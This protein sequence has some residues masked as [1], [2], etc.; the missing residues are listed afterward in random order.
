M[1]T[2]KGQKHKV[3]DL[4]G[5][6]LFELKAENKVSVEQVFPTP[7]LS[8]QTAAA[9]RCKAVSIDIPIKTSIIWF[10]PEMNGLMLLRGCC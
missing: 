4:G 6:Q 10:V 2:L 7:S 9:V 1:T 5:G 8:F 3:A